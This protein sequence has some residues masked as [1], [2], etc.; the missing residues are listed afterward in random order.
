MSTNIYSDPLFSGAEPELEEPESFLENDFDSDEDQ[1][2][3]EVQSKKLLKA[4]LDIY[5]DTEFC[6][7]GAISIQ[8]YCVFIYNGGIYDFSLIIMHKFFESVFDLDKLNVFNSK[9][10]CFFFFLFFSFSL[11][12]F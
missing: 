9:N 4:K 2:K 11:F 6:D 3:S 8:A 5:L 7:E 12:F 1:E 10:N